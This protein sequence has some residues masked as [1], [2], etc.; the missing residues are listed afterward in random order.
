VHSR[1]QDGQIATNDLMEVDA[2][3]VKFDLAGRHSVFAP[4]ACRV[5]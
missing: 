1:G 4:F 5:T 2:P 3:E